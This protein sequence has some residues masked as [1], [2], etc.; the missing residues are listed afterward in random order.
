MHKWM[1][2][3][4]CAAAVLSLAV[5]SAQTSAQTSDDQTRTPSTR[6]GSSDTSPQTTGTERG[7]TQSN[8]STNT[9]Q[10]VT[11]TGCLMQGTDARSGSWMLS[12]ASPAASSS[13]SSS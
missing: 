5:A 12:N 11:M 4:T 3:S 6:S 9:A 10:R 13:I 1:I 8:R 2:G 7:S